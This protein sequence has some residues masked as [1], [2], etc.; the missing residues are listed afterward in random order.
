M[1]RTL[2]LGAISLAASFALIGCADTESS[3]ETGLKTGFFMDSAVNGAHY[4]T[5]SGIEGTTDGRGKFTYNEGDSVEFSLGKIVLG[6]AEP[7][8]DGLITPKNLVTADETPSTDEENTIILLLQTLQSLDSDNNPENGIT[9]SQDVIEKLESLSEE[10]TFEEIDEQTLITIDNEHDLGLDSDYDGHLDVEEDDAKTHFEHTMQ[11][12]EDGEY[13][14]TEESATQDHEGED[15]GKKYQYGKDDEHGEGGEDEEHKEFSLDDYPQT[16]NISQDLKDA[17]AYMGNEE[18]LA[19]DVYKNLYNYHVSNN[20]TEIKQLNNIADKSETKHIATVQSLVQRYNLQASDLSDVN[21]TI[22][23]QNNMS[24]E[25]TLEAMPS[26]VYDIEKIQ[27]LYNAL[28]DLG[29]QSQEDAM[30]AGCMVEVTDITD[31]DEYILI[32]EESNATD[33]VAA[34]NDLRDGSYKHYWAFDKGLKNLG[35]EN[36]CYFEEDPLLTNKE[37]VYPNEE[38]GENGEE[39]K[40]EHAQ[41]NDNND[42]NEEHAQENDDNDNNEEHADNG[43]DKGKKYG[44]NED[45][46]ERDD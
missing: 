29:I 25:I 20:N 17:L 42:N 31:L 7:S 11:S 32:A 37:G 14:D 18:R 1:K 12:W 43:E 39:N 36:G 5:S 15:N 30:K 23:S 44:K 24:N 2:K 6:E 35:V 26:G 22:T 8:T 34:F 27:T 33:V 21:E 16:E 41:E 45:K 38:H 46:G 13:K 4:K 40:E 19:Y 9:I 28:Y 10:I 3:A